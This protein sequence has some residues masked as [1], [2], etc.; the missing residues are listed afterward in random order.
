MVT[1]DPQ[2]VAVMPGCGALKRSAQPDRT[3]RNDD[4]FDVKV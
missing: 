4:F 1:T 2:V 3:G